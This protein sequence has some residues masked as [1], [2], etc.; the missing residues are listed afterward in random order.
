MSR[1]PFFIAGAWLL[2]AVCSAAAAQSSDGYAANLA[3][4]YGERFWIQGYKDVCISVLPKLRRDFQGAYDEWL[5][6]HEEVVAD[7][8]LRVAALVKGL[9]RDEAE[10]RQNY[11]KYYNAAMRQREEEKGGLRKLPREDLLKQCK[12][13]PG[14]L[15][16]SDSDMYNTH[17]KAFDAIYGKKRP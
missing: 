4:L 1:N 10:Y 13:L 7:L 17:A 14:Y 15:R 8:E 16:G 9:S 12:E 6:R 2:A 5:T 3:T 11:N